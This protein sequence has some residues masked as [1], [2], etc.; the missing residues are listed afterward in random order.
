MAATIVEAD[1]PADP[2]ERREALNGFLKQ[3]VDRAV[4]VCAEARQAALRSE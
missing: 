2:E 3:F 4:G 1:L